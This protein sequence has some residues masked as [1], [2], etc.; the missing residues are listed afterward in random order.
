MSVEEVEILDKFRELLDRGDKPV[1]KAYLDEQN[2][3]A[4]AELIGELPEE[5]SLIISSL[6]VHRAASTF[7]I[8]D[9]GTQKELI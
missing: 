2:I 1:L 7:K 6:S 5:Q 8:L 9:F 3:S 4:V